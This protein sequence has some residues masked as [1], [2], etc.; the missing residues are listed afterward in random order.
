MILLIIRFYLLLAM[1]CTTYIVIDSGNLNEKTREEK[2]GSIMRGEMEFKEYE[3]EFEYL[4][5]QYL[6]AEINYHTDFIDLGENDDEDYG[7]FESFQLIN[8][9]KTRGLG[10]VHNRYYWW[11]SYASC[12]LFQSQYAGAHDGNY[13]Y[14][15]PISDKNITIKGLQTSKK[16][17][18]DWYSTSGNGGIFGSEVKRAVA[19]QLHI[20]PPDTDGAHTDWA[21]KITRYYSHSMEDSIADIGDTSEIAIA[22]EFAP[23]SIN[24]YPNPSENYIIVEG[25]FTTPI[26]YVISDV[27][28]KK[29]MDGVLNNSL[30]KISIENF[31]KGVYL[32]IIYG[33]T[34]TYT[35]KI[36][37]L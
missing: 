37:K 34:E 16:Y 2:F 7:D 6:L 20:K 14:Q 33:K 11:G 27:C 5:N 23:V 21:Y 10:W 15:I 29:L 32:M 9:N 17:N 13:F 19:G 18:V 26:V 24:I 36:I 12:Y 31:S 25:N 3:D 30:E 35:F 4:T 28:N 1:P 22:N 8:F